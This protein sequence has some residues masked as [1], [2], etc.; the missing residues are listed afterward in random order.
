VNI[1]SSKN[2]N[3]PLEK[4]LVDC[5]DLYFERLGN[6]DPHAVLE[7]VTVVIEK[8]TIEYVLKKTNG[9]LTQAS[10]VLGITRSTLRKKIL[11]YELKFVRQTNASSYKK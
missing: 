11:K 5:L 6:Q 3:P 2:I 10:K 8:P 4:T 9:N 7:M 1:K